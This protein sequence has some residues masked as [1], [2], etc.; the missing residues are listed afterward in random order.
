MPRVVEPRTELGRVLRSLR[1]QHGW[2]MRDL[3][4][5]TGLSPSYLWTVE[6]GYPSHQSRPVAPRLTALRRLGDALGEGAFERLDA[7]AAELREPRQY[8]PGQAA[9]MRPLE[10]E[11]R[12]YLS[13]M[14]PAHREL[15]RK[16]ARALAEQDSEAVEDPA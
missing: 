6:S 13:R 14:S 11:I 15:V 10:R 9:N 7:A 8:R 2:T 1:E 16:M 5:R 4:A 3:A 12:G